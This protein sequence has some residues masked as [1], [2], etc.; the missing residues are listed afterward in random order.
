MVY[1]R[2]SKLTIYA[3]RMQKLFMTSERFDPPKRTE[4][5]EKA[6]SGLHESKSINPQCATTPRG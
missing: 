2:D 1:L 6:W 3:Y 5:G 4:D